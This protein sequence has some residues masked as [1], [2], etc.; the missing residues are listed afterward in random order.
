MLRVLARPQQPLSAGEMTGK[1]GSRFQPA[2]PP[3]AKLA[4][5]PISVWQP[6]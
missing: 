6:W 2:R 4:P 3:Q 1:G 5:R